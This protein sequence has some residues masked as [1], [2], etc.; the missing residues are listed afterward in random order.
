MKRPSA[1]VGLIGLLGL[2]AC[3]PPGPIAP[4]HPPDHPRAMAEARGL[5]IAYQANL[6]GE[7]EPCG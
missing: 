3:P 2:T 1:L 6:L 5:T 4:A 7:I